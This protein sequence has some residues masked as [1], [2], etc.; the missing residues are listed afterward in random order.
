MIVG[1]APGADEDRQGEPFVGRAGKL[2]D[3][4]LFA[5]GLHRDQVYIANILKS[6][7]PNNRDPRPDEVQACWPF[8]LRQ[9]GLV[10]PGIIFAVGRI[11]AQNLLLTDLPVGKLRG[12]VHRFGENK[13]P[14][15]VSYHP[16]YL[17]RAPAEKQKVWEDLQLAQRILNDDRSIL[18]A[19]AL[20]HDES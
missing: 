17:L 10:E 3:A 15:V 9:I 16:A 2:L 18:T 11:A 8:L 14:V 13:I 12:R 19:S 5:L 7:P 20:R 6:R 1:E 4:M